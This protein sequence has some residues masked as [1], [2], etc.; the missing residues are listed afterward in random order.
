MK[1]QPQ[2]FDYYSV[3]HDQGEYRD[4]TFKNSDDPWPGQRNFGERIHGFSTD[5][6][7][8]KA[9]RWMKAQDKSQPFLMCCHFKATHEP[10]DFPERMRHLYDGVVFPEP[11]NLLDWGPETNGRTFVGQKLETIGHNW[12]V[13]SADPD[14]WWC[15]YP[16]LPFTTKGMSRIAARKA[17]YQKLIRDY[18]RCAATVDDNIGKLLDALDEMGIADNTIVVYVADQGYFLGEHGF[19]D[20]RMFYEESARMPF[21]IRY[22]KCIPAG[23]RVNELVLNVDFASTLCD[24]AGVKSP[25]GTQGRSFKDVL[26]GK[27]PK[28]WRKSIYYRYWTQHDIRPAHIGVRNERYKLIFL[29]GDRLNMTGSSDYKSTPSWEFYDLQKDP[30]ENHNAYGEKEYES[31]I[32]EMKKEMMRLREEVKDTDEGEIRMMEILRKE[33]LEK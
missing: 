27:T 18:L 2:G 14:K 8:E 15:R 17:I 10:Y 5:I 1:S 19:Y 33:G 30:K 24:F 6:V 26:A 12:E 21:V 20:K 3:F 29:Y 7:T 11:E 13:A 9:I 28:D 23:K 32:R 25:E 22:P 4:P 31:V 16:E